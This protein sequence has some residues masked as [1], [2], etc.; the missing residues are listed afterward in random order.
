M[1]VVEKRLISSTLEE[2]GADKTVTAERLGISMRT[3]YRKLG[4]YGLTG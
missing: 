3:L 1:E 2:C 4:K